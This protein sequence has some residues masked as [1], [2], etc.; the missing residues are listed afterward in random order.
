MA[1]C[2]L[3]RQLAQTRVGL[4]T[5]Y[6]GTWRGRS[7]YKW[8]SSSNE[9]LN[10]HNFCAAA[11]CRA[12]ARWQ[13]VPFT[14]GNATRPQPSPSPLLAR[15]ATAQWPGAPMLA[16]SM[17]WSAGQ[18]LTVS[19]QGL[20]RVSVVGV[21]H[22]VKAQ[23][24]L[25]QCFAVL[26]IYDINIKFCICVF[27]LVCL[28][29]QTMHV[30]RTLHKSRGGWDYPPTTRRLT[31]RTRQVCFAWPFLIDERGRQQASRQHTY[32]GASQSAAKSE[33]R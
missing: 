3:V 22:H 28:N 7:R 2:C 25:A 30:S 13:D 26:N 15:A 14:L 18:N 16:C 29:A 6:A 10:E 31:P 9:F 23:R 21:R 1:S 27:K 4:D 5:Q 20:R 33:T 12:L 11:C 17:R 8:A 32:T 24:D 19:R